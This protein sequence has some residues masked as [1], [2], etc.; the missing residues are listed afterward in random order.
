M[1]YNIHVDHSE[2]KPTKG[3]PVWKPG[4][5]Q[6]PAPGLGGRYWPFRTDTVDT[7]SISNSVQLCFNHKQGDLTDIPN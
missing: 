5:V 2:N 3:R 1:M 7:K 6:V 4:H